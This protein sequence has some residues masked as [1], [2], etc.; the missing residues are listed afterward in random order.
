MVY[1]PFVHEK[2]MRSARDIGM[3]CDGK[4]TNLIWVVRHV[5]VEVIEVISPKVFDISRVDPSMAVGRI[6]DEHHWRQAVVYISIVLNQMV[7]LSLS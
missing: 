5:S 2:H 4:D 3:N 7:H 6:F 1:S